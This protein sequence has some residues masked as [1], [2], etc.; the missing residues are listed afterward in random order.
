[1][2][3]TGRWHTLSVWGKIQT[4]TCHLQYTAESPAAFFSPAGKQLNQVS[5]A[6]ATSVTRAWSITD[7]PP[8][9]T[10]YQSPGRNS[11]AGYTCQGMN[12]SLSVWTRVRWC[13]LCLNVCW[14]VSEANFFFFFFQI[15]WIFLTSHTI[16]VWFH[17]SLRCRPCW[18]RLRQAERWNYDNCPRRWC[19]LGCVTATMTH[20]QSEHLN[21]SCM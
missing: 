1:M 13:F 21:S 2:V 14:L 9:N 15:N 19:N 5:E 18:H 4:A 8:T 17:Y 16:S 11:Q 7:F 6:H 12:T 10:D 3:F 20:S